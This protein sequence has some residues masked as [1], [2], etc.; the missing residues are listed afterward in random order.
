[1]PKLKVLNLS[2]EDRKLNNLM[3][4]KKFNELIRNVTDNLNNNIINMTIKTKK[5]SQIVNKV[6]DN[7]NDMIESIRNYVLYKF[8]DTYEE[9][10]VV[11][12]AFLKRYQIAMKLIRQ[13]I[14]DQSSDNENNLKS[15]K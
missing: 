5:E 4:L 12:N 6:C 1:M 8:D 10:V 3:I 14:D 9:N 15:Q 13:I 7:L 2:E 11:Y